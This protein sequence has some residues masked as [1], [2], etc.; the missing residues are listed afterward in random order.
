M[1]KIQPTNKM[2]KYCVVSSFDQAFAPFYV[3]LL[4]SIVDNTPSG[5]GL[6]VVLLVDGVSDFFKREITEIAEGKLNLRVLEA[7][8][9]VGEMEFSSFLGKWPLSSIFRLWIPVMFEGYEKV[10]YLDCDTLVKNGYE[11]I[12]ADS[13][14]EGGAISAVRDRALENPLLFKRM[15][16]HVKS[17]LGEKSSEYVNSGVLVF[18]FPF[19]EEGY[20]TNLFDV[21]ERCDAGLFPDQDVINLLFDGKKRFLDDKYNVQFGFCEQD[22]LSYR[23]GK[24]GVGEVLIAHF[25]GKS[26]PWTTFL[27]HEVYAYYWEIVLKTKVSAYIY[28]LNAYVRERQLRVLERKRWRIKAWFALFKNVPFLSRVLTRKSRQ[29]QAMEGDRLYLLSWMERMYF[30]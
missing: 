5:F 4:T 18:S 25:T 15:C 22:R 7:R 11:R 26:K 24:I 19:F 20:R 17:L 21:I 16:A 1:K 30:R 9:G 14:N 13:C 8:E 27:S 23:K 12:F 2:V 10:L 6:D 3:P 28:S 29:F